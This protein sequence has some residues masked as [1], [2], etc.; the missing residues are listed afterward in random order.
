MIQIFFISP[1]GQQAAVDS[2]QGIKGTSIHCWTADGAKQSICVAHCGGD[3][4]HVA[5]ALE[6]AGM[7]L[8]PDHRSGVVVPA[9]VVT[10]LSTYGVTATD[11]T[12][13]AMAK[14]KAVSGWVTHRPRRYM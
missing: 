12:N 13:T 8:M 3:A 14:V 11:T 7:I 4:E 10:A 2:A 6:N 1:T 5:I 9:A